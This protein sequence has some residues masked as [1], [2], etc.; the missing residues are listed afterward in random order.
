M[1][2]NTDWEEFK[3]EMEKRRPPLGACVVPG[4]NRQAKHDVFAGDFSGGMC[5]PCYLAY[6]A[7]F[8][9]GQGYYTAWAVHEAGEDH[10]G[11]R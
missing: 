11:I 6:R 7:G 4:C 10:V 3:R 5:G 8:K 1:S 2:E 9:D